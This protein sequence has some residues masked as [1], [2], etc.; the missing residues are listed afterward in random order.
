[1]GK[2]KNIWNRSKA[3]ASKEER[4]FLRFA[5]V[6]TLGFLVFFCVIKRDNLFRWIEAGFTVRNQE[7][8]M[9]FYEADIQRLQ[10]EVRN[11]TT[12]KD[13]LEKYAREKFLF[14]E[15]GED[16]YVEE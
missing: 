1:M 5:I 11:L 16:V 4:S 9:E 3:G 6:V 13:S 10:E 12:D 2:F 8:R 15:P 14:A 7:K